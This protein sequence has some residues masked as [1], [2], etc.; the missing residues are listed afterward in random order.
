[1]WSRPASGA[2][3]RR[4]E[5]CRARQPSLAFVSGELL[6]H[7]SAI[8]GQV[9]GAKVDGWQAIRARHISG[10]TCGPDQYSTF[11]FHTTLA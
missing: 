9:S 8:L 7:R 10:R 6:V 11:H 5:S 4:F 2:K 3:G 1:M